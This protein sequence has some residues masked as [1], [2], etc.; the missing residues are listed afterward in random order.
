MK[1]ILFI[2]YCLLSFN[3]GFSQN[4]IKSYE[5]WF[6][7]DF[8]SKVTTTITPVVS[9][10]LAGT[11][12]TAG[13]A[14]GLHVFNVRFKDDSSRYSQVTS[15]FFFK[16][17]QGGAAVQTD[18]VSYEYW[19]DNDYASKVSAIIVATPNF[20]LSGNV[21]AALASPGLHVMNI[22]FKDSG[23]KWSQVVSSFFYK[24]DQG[25]V[26]QNEIK[27]YE[28][29]FDNDY[30]NKINTSIAPLQNF[31]LQSNLTTNLLPVGL[32]V[33]N[34]RFKDVSGKWSQVLSQFFTKTQSSQANQQLITSFQYWFDNDFGS[35]IT[36]AVTPVA[37]YHLINSLPTGN[38]PEGLH[39]VTIRFKDTT[40]LWSQALTQFIYKTHPIMGLSNVIVGYRYWADDNIASA[41]YIQLASPINDY[42]V[43][44]SINMLN[45]PKG[46][47]TFNIQF[48]DTTH[49]WSV[50]QTDSFF[51][52]PKPMASFYSNATE[53]CDTGTVS[54]VN[55]SFDTDLYQ[56]DFGDGYTSTDSTPVHFYAAS[57]SYT[58]T[59]LGTDTLM[60][61]QDDTIQQAYITVH[62]LPTVTA[63]VTDDTLCLGQ[64][65]TLIAQGNANTYTWSNGLVNNQP[66]APVS[67]ATYTLTGSN[68]I[69]SNT[70]SIEVVV[71]PLPIVSVATV[72]PNDTVCN[73][74]LVTLAGNGAASYVWT[75][76]QL[77]F[78]NTPFMALNS[79]VYTVVGTDAN[80]C[81]N[82]ATMLLT[83]QALPN[84]T[85]ASIVP[86]D[87]IC[88][89]TAVT[90]SGAGAL[91]Y[92]WSGPQPIINASP[93]NANITGTYIL[94]GTDANGC[95]NSTSALLTVH[96][97][98][99]VTIGAV[100]P[101]DT[102]CSGTLLTLSGAGAISYSWAGPQ[103]ITDATPFTAF[104]TGIYTVTGSNA[105]SCTNTAT[106][107]IEVS[108]LPSVVVSVV[109]P[110]DTL[111]EGTSLTLA[112]G[113]AI[114]YTWNG[115]QV[116]TDNIPFAA[117]T[118]GI[119]TVT[120]TD[121]NFCSNSSSIAITVNAIPQFS[122]GAD[123]SICEGSQLTL[124]QPIIGAVVLWNDNSSADT[125]TVNQLGDYWCN[126]TLNGCI[127]ADTISIGIDSLPVANFGYTLLNG[128][129]ATTD[130]SKFAT[131]YK[132]YFG[133]GDSAMIASPTHTYLAIGIYT[134]SLIAFNDCG[135]DTIQRILEVTLVDGVIS[136]QIP[137]LLIYPNPT[138]GQ[139]F[140]DLKDYSGAKISV[141]LLDMKGDCVF[142]DNDV[143]SGGIAKLDFSGMSEGMYL[144][145]IVINQ[146]VFVHRI[147]I[148]K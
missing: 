122:L 66:F 118:S 47:R 84:V 46:D 31:N 130:S 23:G 62:S 133:D 44:T 26:A 52:T 91:S 112:G 37:D 99:L 56:W 81:S 8:L 30:V 55:N 3:Q 101:N 147:Q 142:R 61:L 120:G 137:G 33:V 68:G 145:R 69:C 17:F 59:L 50:V 104:T 10:Q 24:G 63:T 16:Q 45:V 36:Q 116:I 126:V 19:F 97:L 42:N 32:H 100:S 128:V 108:A 1:K 94:T 65:T 85:V 82:S 76:P 9:Y 102:V 88:S 64:S 93:F 113:G 20:Q 89:G 132:W 92:L 124:N 79:G 98:P 74:T 119:Y 41:T 143:S 34:V 123:T 114:T 14:G 95:S 18:I 90:M 77:L 109:D 2:M 134:L 38:M 6:D 86:N 28:Y 58:V 39:T 60:N 27:E 87:S 83:V 15:S 43:S 129:L 78:D 53:F 51:R 71:H 5:Y 139:L 138:A 125:L 140:I 148:A 12:P 110:N 106:Q 73:G 144:L 4:K 146:R 70:D 105:F 115:P 35:Q 96:A 21:S 40:N 75:G 127:Y 57:G 103:I 141:L 49:R 117:T 80:L 7:N 54:F 135:S 25:G 29:W 13:L 111:C 136:Q 22:R 11:I 72:N 121:G 131:S 48:L 107:A 67:T